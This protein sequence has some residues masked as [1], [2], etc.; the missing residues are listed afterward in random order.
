MYKILRRK[1][2]M[3]KLVR[4]FMFVFVVMSFIL[5]ACGGGTATEAPIV[6]PIAAPAEPTAAPTEA[7]ATESPAEDPMTMYAPD[8]VSGDIV[9]AG[10][11][12]V[13]PLSE[14]MKQRFE[15]EGF[16]GNL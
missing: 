5:A 12:T 1:K 10:S 9:T 4:T 8:A 7:P 6:E 11:S 15:E 2:E 16:A 13:F 14:R 3:T